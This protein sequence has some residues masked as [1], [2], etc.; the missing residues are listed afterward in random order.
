MLSKTTPI[1][2]MLASFILAPR[3]FAADAIEIKDVKK[4]ATL[5]MKKTVKPA[6]IGTELG[7]ML[8]SVFAYIGKKQ[9]KPL[10]PMPVTRYTPGKGETLDIEAG[11]VVPDGTKGEGEIVASE[12]PAGKVAFTVHVGPYD[13][14]QKT[15][16]KLKAFIAAK[17]LKSA[18]TSWE[19]YISDPGDT[20][21]EDLKTEIYM[22][23][24]A[25]K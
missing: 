21:P 11:V 16:D 14:F 12:L 23:L 1:A 10:L 5:V 3:L 19:V 24:E 6:D 22:L 17:N 13:Q 8:P 7:K 9:I 4:Q 2:L 25:A 15:Y 20:K 18:G